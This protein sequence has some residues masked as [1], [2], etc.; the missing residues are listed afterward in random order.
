MF[1]RFAAIFLFSFIQ[2]N[3]KAQETFT[4][5]GKNFSFKY[6]NFGPERS[7]GQSAPSG[8]KG[9]LLDLP[10]LHGHGATNEVLVA[11]YE[12]SPATTFQKW[13]DSVFSVRALNGIIKK[14][15]PQSA[16]PKLINIQGLSAMEIIPF[17]DECFAREV[18]INRDNQIVVLAWMLDESDFKAR[19]YDR[20]IFENILSSFKWKSNQP[21]K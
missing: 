13:M 15:A 7:Q 12:L 9:T 14:G 18:Y 17:C 11:S 10:T 1:Y 3:V 6:V 5:E 4:F 8:L 20:N 19:E 2:F 16:K 21:M